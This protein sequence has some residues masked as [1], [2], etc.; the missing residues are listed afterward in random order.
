MRLIF[1]GLLLLQLFACGQQAADQPDATQGIPPRTELTDSMQET[2]YAMGVD[3]GASL[4]MFPT[5]LDIPSLVQGIVDTLRGNPRLLDDEK[6][7]E[8]MIRFS[9]KMEEAQAALRTQQA[10]QNRQDGADFLQKN[11]TRPEVKVTGSGLQYEVT[12]RGDGP[13]P[14]DTDRV[15]IHYRGYFLNEQ[16][17]DSSYKRGEPVTV[18]LN[19]VIPGWREGVQLMPVGSVFRFYI[20]GGLAYGEAGAPPVIGPDETLIFDVELLDI[21]Q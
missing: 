15:Q 10:A 1:V 17:F 21:V 13:R 20:P 3:I 11:M 4:R 19:E 16:E 5:R 18:A 7:N 9:G 8:I 12:R 2:S 6:L 14:R